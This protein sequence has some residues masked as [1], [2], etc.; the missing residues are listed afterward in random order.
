MLCYVIDNSKWLVSWQACYFLDKV[1]E[2]A[3][4]NPVDNSVA[5]DSFDQHIV[6]FIYTKKQFKKLL[7]LVKIFKTDK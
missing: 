6:Q 5:S 3:N 1:V 4:I 2:S 7:I